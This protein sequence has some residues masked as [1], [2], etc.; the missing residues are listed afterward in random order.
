MLT[1]FVENIPLRD[2]GTLTALDLR[3]FIKEDTLHANLLDSM[4]RND[5]TIEPKGVQV[6]AEG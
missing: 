2:N 4:V 5:E 3:K 6:S 1:V